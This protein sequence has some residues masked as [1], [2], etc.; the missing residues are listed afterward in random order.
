MPFDTLMPGIFFS[1]PSTSESV[2]T[3]KAPA[4]AAHRVALLRGAQR[5]ASFTTATICGFG[6]SVDASER[7]LGAVHGGESPRLGAVADEAERGG[8]FAV[9]EARHAQRA[10]L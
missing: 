1:S 4:L 3:L 8:V 6:A 9:G 5:L 2:V 7:A 10:P